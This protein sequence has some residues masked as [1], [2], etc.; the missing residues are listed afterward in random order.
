MRA[1][2]RRGHVRTCTVEPVPRDARDAVRV[3]LQEDDGALLQCQLSVEPRQRERTGHRVRHHGVRRPGLQMLRSAGGA[4]VEDAPGARGGTGRDQGKHDGDL[5]V[6]RKVRRARD[7]E[8][9]KRCSRCKTTFYCSAECQKR[10]Y[11][12][13]KA[14]CTPAEEPKAAASE[15]LANAAR[16]SGQDGD[17]A[18][19]EGAEAGEGR[20]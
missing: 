6:V 4:D 12:L 14:S 20:D 5:P 10:H 17:Q 11:P 13:H 18:S 3:V 9:I 16:G 7:Q 2:A 15:T 19:R 1:R 8:G